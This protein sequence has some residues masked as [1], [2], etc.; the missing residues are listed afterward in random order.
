MDWQLFVVVLDLDGLEI[1]GLENLAALEAFDVFHALSAGNHL[2]TGMVA[3]GLHKQR[4][5]E[6]YFNRPRS[7]V[8]PP[9]CSELQFKFYA[10]PHPASSPVARHRNPSGA[11]P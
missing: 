3:S 6:V 2:G 9:C 10:V 8:K 11:G 7:V 4:L 1:F 5:D